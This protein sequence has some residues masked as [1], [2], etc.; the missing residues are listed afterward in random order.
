MYAIGVTCG[1]L[2][3][4]T[5]NVIQYLL[6]TIQDLEVRPTLSSDSIMDTTILHMSST[7]ASKMAI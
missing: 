1:N 6:T 3:L 2:E 5:L 4:D 7:L